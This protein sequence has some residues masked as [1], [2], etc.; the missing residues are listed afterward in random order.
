LKGWAHS[1]GNE[2]SCKLMLA[3][4]LEPLFS[5]RAGHE[6]FQGGR[7]D[8]NWMNREIVCLFEAYWMKF[9]SGCVHFFTLCRL[10]AVGHFTASQHTCIYHD[11]MMWHLLHSTALKCRPAL[12]EQL[13]LAF[14][15]PYADTNNA[16]K[17]AVRIITMLSCIIITVRWIAKSQG[18]AIWELRENAI[19]GIFSV[20]LLRKATKNRFRELSI[21]V[22]PVHFYVNSTEFEKSI[23]RSI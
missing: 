13:S 11:I 18:S 8:R 3:V 9:C 2:E 5:R 16:C 17:K 23:E 12:P 10:C 4:G 21:F 15:I 14:E 7:H 1:K 20:P 19:F 22:S 6:M